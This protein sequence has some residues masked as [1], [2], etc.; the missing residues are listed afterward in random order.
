MVYDITFV[1]YISIQLFSFKS[2]SEKHI[3]QVKHFAVNEGNIFFFWIQYK[4]TFS[5]SYDY[6]LHNRSK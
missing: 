3:P 2:M 6:Y 1:P 4:T 5:I